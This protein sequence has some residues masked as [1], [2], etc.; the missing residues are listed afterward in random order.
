MD[1][2]CGAAGGLRSVAQGCIKVRMIGDT[3]LFWI[4]IS[5]KLGQV[6]GSCWL[7]EASAE[8]EL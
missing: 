2:A 5:N 4:S 8:P 6:A 3:L 1:G 7:L